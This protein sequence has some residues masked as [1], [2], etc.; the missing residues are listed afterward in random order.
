M[1][2]QKLSGAR[3]QAPPVPTRDSGER[4]SLAVTHGCSRT[5][6]VLLLRLCGMDLDNGLDAGT[7]STCV[8][9]VADAAQLFRVLNMPAEL[10]RAFLSLTFCRNKTTRLRRTIV[11]R[12]FDDDGVERFVLRRDAGGKRVTIA[13][14]ESDAFD[15]STQSHTDALVSKTVDV[16][17]ISGVGPS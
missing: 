2:A 8:V 11:Q 7:L 12:V 14:R 3:P 4:L 15:V 10:R 16:E 5:A 1:L 9:R 17:R 6:F 13:V